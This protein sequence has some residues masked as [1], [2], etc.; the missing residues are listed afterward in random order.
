MERREFIGGKWQIL[1]DVRDFIQKNYTLYEGDA[2]FL[3]GPTKKTQKVWGRCLELLAEELKKMREKMTSDVVEK[4][5][6]IKA[7][8]E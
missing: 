8:F 4:D 6:K 7:Q 5:K 1:I 2:S 3:K